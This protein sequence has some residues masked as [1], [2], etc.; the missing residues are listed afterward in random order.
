MNINENKIELVPF[1][2]EDLEIFKKWLDKEHVYKWFYSEEEEKSY[3]LDEAYNANVKNNP[4]KHFIVKSNSEKIGYCLYVDS[5][6]QSEYSQEVYGEI[7]LEKYAYEI[8]YFI[9]E[10]KY[11]NKGIGKIIVK[12]LEEKIIEIGGK[13]ILADP[14]EENIISVKMLLSGGFTKIKNG[15]YVKKL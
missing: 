6:F 10:E 11:L 5:H 15:A 13:E 7:F 14:D 8:N 1:L 3:Y 12:K 4:V 2:D 9:G